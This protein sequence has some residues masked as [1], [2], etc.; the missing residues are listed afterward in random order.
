MNKNEKLVFA[1]NN[2]HKLQEARQIISDGFEIMSLAEIG[3][4]DDIPE[5]ADTLEGNA[6]IKAR[7]VKERY[8]YDC[9]ADDTGLMV[10]ALNGAPGVY[11]ARYAGEHC[12]PADNVA[13]LLAEMEGVENRNAHFATTVALICDGEEHC[14]EGRVEGK[15]ATEPHGNGGF[16]YDP[17][18][19][20]DETG[21]C[22]AEMTADDKNAIS[23]RGRAMRRLKEFLGV[24]VAFLLMSA[25]C[26]LVAGASEWRL[27]PSYNGQ[28]ERVVETPKY[29][30]FLGTA[31]SYTRG[32]ITN[33][34]LDGMLF[35]YD[36][37]G[38]E[39]TYLSKQNLLSGR[40]VRSIEFNHDK[41]Y[42]VVAYDDGNIDMIYD[43]G[44]VINIPGLMLADAS[45]DK[46]VNNINFDS[47][48]NRIYLATQF[49]YVVVNDELKEIETSRN[50]GEPII[51]VVPF[52]GNL[53][54]A[55]ENAIYYGSSQ[56]FD[57]TKLKK[58]QNVSAMTRMVPVGK[59]Y[60]YLL[61]GPANEA[62]CNRIY[63]K[64]PG[65]YSRASVSVRPERCF[66]VFRD[67]VFTVNY[68]ELCVFT[69]DGKT[70]KYALTGDDKGA[71]AGTLDGTEFWFCYQRK[72][73]ARRCV[74]KDG[75]TAWTTLIDNFM[76][77]AANPFTCR[78]MAYH[79]DYGMLVRNNSMDKV[80]NNE[81]KNYA[82]VADLISGYKDMTWTPLSATYRVPDMKGIAFQNPN[83]IAIDPNN[84][85][86]V[87]CGSPRTGL[88]RYDLAHPEKSL[89]MSKATDVLGGNGHTGFVVVAPEV[90]QGASW[91]QQCTFVAPGF[92]SYGNLWTAYINPAIKNDGN[93]VSEYVEFWV[94]TAADRAASTSATDFRDWKKIKFEG[95]RSGNAALMRPL[96]VGAN[97]NI[98]IYHG[99]TNKSELIVFDHGG[100]PTTTSDD[101]TV[102]FATVTN[103]DG[104][105]SS[106]VSVID[107]YED[108]LTG[109]VWVSNG[110]G[111]F[112]FDP[113]EALN[114]S[115][116]IRRIKVP[117]NDGTNL[118]D[119]LLDNV[120]VNRITSDGNGRKWFATNGGGLVCTSSDGREIIRTYTPDNSEIP[121]NTVYDVCYNPS[122]GSLM[123]STDKGLAE[124]FLS[125][126]AGESGDNGVRAYPN[127]V[128]PDFYGYVTIDG[129]PDGAMVK[130]VDTY[131]N[132]VRECGQA[133]GGVV[134]WDVTN[135]NSKRVPGGVYFVIATN[136]PGGDSFSKMTKILV[137]E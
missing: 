107:M 4:H 121:G 112:T 74:P 61:H 64:S 126:S 42:L 58:F 127:P 75:S 31:K 33:G 103:Q 116:S 63:E 108:P 3:C 54:F 32:A 56:E 40:L 102:H 94:W 59:D 38:E 16:G 96:K 106:L 69:K 119:Y 9:F 19:I 133:D 25:V 137:V 37:E 113:K 52:K 41:N 22:F 122:T 13:K 1:T 27:H 43:N 117:R 100:T 53:W 48:N 47:A 45:L 98:I 46:T 76:F 84:T 120:Q 114:G 83:G 124:L 10:D 101:K 50:F 7:W 2:A 57:F 99:N 39:M 24:F 118:A 70:F 136:G 104:N 5:T 85:D 66:E 91:Q 11:S 128:R 55:T 97:K 132:V 35:R 105:S 26:P 23:H 51:S 17:I 8:G 65:I 111:V 131:G 123:M 30:Y 12:S 73:V 79:P 62:Y 20:A 90:P 125:G 68:I 67:G 6:L 81:L 36:K 110:S 34:S 78:S 95:L 86:H 14:F 129:L 89:H 44:D 93:Y 92:D 77:N 80:F 135:N 72:G 18:F 130:V 60:L 15:I 21:K 134:Q 88:L 71:K 115:T 29:T 49:G 82:N 28:M 109:L 87:Y